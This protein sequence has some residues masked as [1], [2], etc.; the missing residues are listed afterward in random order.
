M[1]YLIKCSLW[2][3]QDIGKAETV[4]NIRLN[5]HGKDAGM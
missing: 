3:V 1:I 4:F 2:K 5:N